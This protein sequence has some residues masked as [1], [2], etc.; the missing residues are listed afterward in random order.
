[1]SS[2]ACPTSS[3]DGTYA[4]AA[5]EQA[6]RTWRGWCVDLVFGS[7]PLRM[8]QSICTKSNSV[9]VQVSEPCGIMK[10]MPAPFTVTSPQIGLDRYLSIVSCVVMRR[11]ASLH[12]KSHYDIRSQWACR[13][14]G[15]MG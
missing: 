9:I 1:M 2:F 12:G 14:L 8:A 4:F 3:H 13:G 7:D 5:I 11:Y 10:S 15:E 6:V